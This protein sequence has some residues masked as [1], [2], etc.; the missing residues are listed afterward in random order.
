MERIVVISDT[1]IP[2]QDQYAV[3]NL[4]DFIDAWEPTGTIHIGDLM[5]FPTPS[6]WSKGTGAEFAGSVIEDAKLGRAFIKDLRSATSAWIKV[7]SGNH[8]ARPGLYLKKYAPALAD[9]DVS[10]ASLLDFDEFGI[11]LVEGWLE[12]APNWYATHG[13]LGYTLSQIAGRTALLGAIQDRT[14]LVIGHTHRLGMGGQ[15]FGRQGGYETYVGME[16]GHLCSQQSMG[17]LKKSGGKAN[18]QKGFGILYVDGTSVQPVPVI[19]E[20]DRTFI[21]EGQRFGIPVL[22]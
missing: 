12:I 22:D 17:Y 18:W 3:D 14:N 8:D 1:Q 7:I 16:V 20:P 21:V 6:S 9:V 10:L 13:H 2:F 11:E 15:T 5:E 4:L 19:V